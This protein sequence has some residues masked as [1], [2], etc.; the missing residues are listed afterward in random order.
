MTV[1]FFE[2]LFFGN[3]LEIISLIFMPISSIPIGPNTCIPI[4]GSSETSI[5][6]N[7]SSNSPNSSFFRILLRVLL[8]RSLNSLDFFASSLL[9]SGNNIS[10]IRSFAKCSASSI[11]SSYFSRSTIATA[12]SIRSRTIDSTSL[13]T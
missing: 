1:I 10:I 3:E 6:I 4:E 8:W 11:T 13:P 9:S 7:F 12:V 5:S 2:R